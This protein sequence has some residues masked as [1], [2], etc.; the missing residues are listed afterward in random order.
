MP[1]PLLGLPQPI[2]P[3][4]PMTQPPSDSPP[5]PLDVPLPDGD[6]QLLP[7]PHAVVLAALV[8][9]ADG[10]VDLAPSVER[11]EMATAEALAVYH[12][13]VSFRQRHGGSMGW[14]DLAD[15]R[16]DDDRYWDEIQALKAAGERL[17]AAVEAGVSLQVEPAKPPV[18]PVLPNGLK[19]SELDLDK[20]EHWEALQRAALAALGI[21]FDD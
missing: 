5:A 7:R 17:R 8:L 20:Q 14:S 19:L 11:L 12:R 21:K 15:C 13:S 3:E 6:V 2:A 10:R 1:A 9:D 4:P 18:D 16:D